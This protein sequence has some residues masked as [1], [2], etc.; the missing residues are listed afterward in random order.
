MFTPRMKQRIGT[1]I[2]LI[3]MAAILGFVLMDRAMAC[4]TQTNILRQIHGF[5]SAP[6]HEDVK[7]KLHKEDETRLYLITTID[8]NT[9]AVGEIIFVDGCVQRQVNHF[10][11]DAIALT[12]RLTGMDIYDYLKAVVPVPTPRPKAD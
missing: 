9:P 1:I 2:A 6:G 10:G 7:W 11:E 12:K 3:A 5:Y 4:E 8:G